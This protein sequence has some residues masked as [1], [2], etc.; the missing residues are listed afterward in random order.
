[1]SHFAKVVD[2]LV[3]Q[4]IVA[5]QEYIDLMPDPSQWVQCSYNTRGNVHY[6]PDGA[7]PDDGTPLRGNYPGPG[8]TYDAVNDVFYAPKPFPTA[9]LNTASWTWDEIPTTIFSDPTE[10]PSVP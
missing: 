6:G 3:E 2:G 7:T 4:V 1:M 10:T 9:T 5:E 8:Y